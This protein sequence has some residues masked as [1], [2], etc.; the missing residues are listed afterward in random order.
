MS[1]TEL[2]EARERSVEKIR[3]WMIGPSDGEEEDFVGSPLLRYMMG[4]LYPVENNQIDLADDGTTDDSQSADDDADSS[5]SNPAR[6]QLPS[7]LGMSFLVGPD[8]C[9]ECV[10]EAALYKAHGAKATGERGRRAWRRDRLPS[11]I[12]TVQVMTGEVE[13]LTLG[14]H[15][16]LHINARPWGGGGHLVTVTLINAID[17]GKNLIDPAK[18][19]F[20]VGLSVTVSKG[21]LLPY[22]SARS[23]SASSEDEAEVRYLYR[24]SPVYARGHGVAAEWDECADGRPRTVRASFMPKAEV[25][26]PTFEIQS[27]LLVDER[28]ASVEYLAF[29]SDAEELKRVLATVSSSF[30]RWVKSQHETASANGEVAG[31]VLAKRSED[32]CERID[33]GIELLSDPV[34]YES[35]VLA[36]RAMYWQMI[37][38]KEARNGPF[39]VQDGRCVPPLRAGHDFEWRPFQIAFFLG[40]LPSLLESASASVADALAIRDDR[41]TVDVIWFPTG[42][43]KTEAYLLVAAFELIRRRLVHGA[44]DQACAVLSRYTLRMLTAQQFQRTGMLVGALE[45]MRRSDMARLGSRPFTVGLWV[46][47]SLTP[48]YFKDAV[49]AYEKWMRAPSTEKNPFL[50]DRCPVCGTA[51]V[52]D[53]SGSSGVLASEV[54]FVFK[55]MSRACEFKDEIPMQVVDE[56]LYRSPPSILLGTLDKF[57]GLAWDDRPRAFFGLNDRSGPP[58]SLVIQDE[59]HLI[60]GPLGSIASP[61]ELAIDS[62]IKSRAAGRGAKVIAST[63]TIRNSGEQV[64][65]IYGRPSAVFPSPIRSWDDAFFFR[66]QSTSEVPGRLYVGAMGQGTTTPVVSMVWMAAALLQASKEVALPAKL[67]DAYWTVLAYL[68]SRREL[69]RTITAASQEIPDRIKAIATT[70]DN[71][72]QVNKIMELSSQMASDMGEAIRTLQRKGTPSSPATDFVPC[73][74]IISV[75]V[76]IDRLGLMLINGQ[77]KLTSEYIQAS[78]RVGRSPLVAPGLVVTLYSPAKPRD[79]SHY[80]DFAA[81][82]QSF[83][84]YV[85]PTSVTP[86]AP[87][88]RKRT[89]HAALISMVR[90]ATPYSSND[91][92]GAVPLDDAVVIGLVEQ[93]KTRVRFA[94]SVEADEVWR[95]IDSILHVWKEQN[96]AGGKVVY[97]SSGRQFVGTETALIRD[98]GDPPKWGMF[99]TMR[100]VRNVEP[101]IHLRPVGKSG[102]GND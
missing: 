47:K 1:I 29:N 102:A 85:E 65:G 73:T 69:G 12:E 18:V 13:R 89:L 35:F 15:A 52:D 7:S 19:L 63:A 101:D 74:N 82:H 48:N 30:K 38:A 68:N 94:D 40:V 75:G 22:P 67:D 24:G 92:A 10:A 36:N 90:H 77:P 4:M 88:A 45:L 39:S 56:A 34:A 41:D 100:S 9:L 57:A 16:K 51:I 78:S 95:E 66:L 96:E 21:E 81:Y 60:S 6:R 87:P 58:P 70:S 5:A 28:Y 44:Q 98:F 53:V 33:Q 72:R 14:G 8:A 84:R 91:Q 99:E 50:L 83:Y 11:D 20:Q 86:Y 46:G 43:G 17:A 62:I 23:A 2:S 64:R 79:R 26:A 61:Y 25:R 59:L 54:G 27:D 31:V 49:S 76:D 80:E 97:V 37:M 71:V 55:C 32:W 42:G 3:S 93:F